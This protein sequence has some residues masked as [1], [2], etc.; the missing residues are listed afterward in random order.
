MRTRAKRSSKSVHSVLTFISAASVVFALLALTATPAL[1][2]ESHAF[3]GVSIG[4]GGR[5]VAG[6]FTD[7]Q[8]VA[9]DPSNGDLYVLDTA[10]G[11]RLYKFDSTGEPLD[12]SGTGTN[13]IEGTGGEEFFS[14]NQ[15]AVAPPGAATGTA[16][17]IYIANHEVLK[18]YSPAGGEIGQ[19]NSRLNDLCGV[20]VDASG[21]VFTK[22]SHEPNRVVEYTPTTN[23][24][25]DAD[26]SGVSTVEIPE[27]C[28]LAVDSKGHLYAASE[29]PTPVG[30][31][32]WPLWKIQSLTA[33]T[34]EL[35]D[36]YSSTVTVEPGTDDVY[37]SHG[38][39]VVQ[40]GEDGSVISKF[41]EDRLDQ[42]PGLSVAGANGNVY[43][44]NRTVEA[45]A[46]SSS[47]PGRVDVFGPL[48][49]L[50]KAVAGAVEGI[51]KTSAVLHG[52]IDADGGPPASCEFQYVT[53]AGFE[54]EGFEAASSVPCEPAG[55]FA[56]N[57]SVAV[58]AE[59]LGLAVG[60][61]YFF[62][63][64]GQNVNGELGSDENGSAP[65]KTPSFETLP[66][67]NVQTSF[68]TGPTETSATLTGSINPE[69][70]S[71]S[72]CFF[73]YG[74]TI[75]YGAT[76]PCEAPNA[77][78]IG[79]G[80]AP[81]AVHAVVVGLT[82]S[83]EYHYRLVGGSTQ[84]GGI[85]VP[86]SDVLF[87]TVGPPE[88]L[89]EAFSGVGQSTA[90]I[91][92]S[93][94][95]HSSPTGYV[96]EYVTAKAFA[97]SGYATA[98]KIPAV[99]VAIGSGFTGVAISQTLSGLIPGT[100]YHFRV[101]AKNGVSQV[102]GA[103]QVFTTR[104]SSPLFPSC[105]A[106]EGFRIEW[107]A[108]LPD[109][110]AYE[111]S[112]SPDKNGGSVAG[113]YPMMF[114]SEDGSAVTFYSAAGALPPAQ[115]GGTQN[116]S[117]YLARREVAAGSWS[118]QRLLPPESIGEFAEFLGATP[119]LRYAVVEA[120]SLLAET[121]LFA[122][123]TEDGSVTQIVPYVPSEKRV[124]QFGFDGASADGSRIFFESKATVQTT[125]K[126]PAPAAGHDNLYMW[127]R[128]T[129]DVSLVGVLP[130]VGGNEEAPS[131]GSFG[132][133]YE[134]YESESP[135]TGG[136]LNQPG[137][138]FEPLAVAGLHAISPSGE[139]V[140]FT[141]A[142][143]GQL[144]LR[145]GLG[146]AD[147]TTVH[148]STPNS[149]VSSPSGEFPAA[150]LE[151]TPDGSRAFFMSRQQLTANAASGQNPGEV[152]LYRW[153][154]SAPA[155][156]GLT[157]IAPGAEVQGLLGVNAA[158][159]A[160]YFTA[161]AVLAPKAEAGGENLYR[162]AEK[163][164]GGFRITFIATLGG[165]G[166]Q[167]P[168]R[169]NV[170]PKVAM[171][172]PVGKTSRLTENG[173]TL[174]F[175][176][177]ESLTEYN[178]FNLEGISCENGHCPE[179]YLYSANTGK[180]TCVSCDPTGEAPLGAA[181]LQ[182]QFFNAYFTPNEPP[183]VLSSRNLS[184]DG[185]R[186][187]FQTPDPLVSTDE[188]GSSSCIAFGGQPGKHNLVGPG[189]CQDVYEWEAVGSGSCQ[190]EEANG[191]CLYLLSTGQSDQ[192]SYFI[193]ASKDGSSAF[194]S[195]TSQLVPV[196]RDQADDVYDV[197]EGGGLA[198]QQVRP[199][200]P[201][202]SAEACKSSVSAAPP[203][204]SPATLSFQGPGNSKT[205]QCKKGY[206]AKKGKCVKKVKKQH[207]KPVKKHAH[208]AKRATD[209]KRSGGAK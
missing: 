195:T 5:A 68:A 125:P 201:C 139:Q 196:D 84:F 127:E 165:G 170:S 2:I 47:Y 3:T 150:F 110:R 182:D 118:S 57:S 209:K 112:S 78:E 156:E 1:A 144:Y 134:W 31:R 12:F 52:S 86:A 114:A 38:I 65:G 17:D 26:Q 104:G 199:L 32:T 186:V 73:E 172:Y 161:R 132:G 41:G 135:A 123:N 108:S 18:I 122:I 37:V 6:E 205:K 97:E 20:T 42:A 98:T 142:V 69:G 11:G 88:I 208:K 198:S 190:R 111:Q 43:V 191:G 149:G 206:V 35:F 166:G 120:G 59:A 19:I 105:P 79:T 177:S 152:D 40:Y 9:V 155:A 203:A 143:T 70:V 115:R 45:H 100:K 91:S 60:S 207:K 169:R 121:G 58:S 14:L 200:V 184:A 168:D 148:I 188:N 53:Q 16:G 189:R 48:V 178:N 50:P 171:T 157:D 87:G 71:I 103:D 153:D 13:F 163:A 21:D 187:F 77:G 129:G 36:S 24:P 90:T 4:P 30:E 137:N 46:S 54:A 61:K 185:T 116:Y 145:R 29:S 7:L 101:F 99:E 72:E 183:A 124:I 27:T 131:A 146:T 56:G 140:F 136:T 34:K 180:V 94:N 49:K 117:T 128:S 89:S 162:F 23:P 126:T 151:A 164:A 66:A 106:N 28:N 197:R 85:R 15:V 80:S 179:F 133:A 167:T 96:V 159:T 74:K 107:S 147:P 67:F 130:A 138:P 174:L 175:A 81:V 51:T 194:I 141:S 102:P 113:L 93:I 76:A 92:G 39:E 193:G 55:P 64:V 8:S 109:C 119:D 25:T 82:G 160:G 154:A 63:L 10:N 202:S 181:S 33:D 62:R 176:S 204:T 83:S 75:A 95:P 192:P 22:T 173:E 44:S 158:G